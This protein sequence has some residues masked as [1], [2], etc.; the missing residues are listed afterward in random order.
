METNSGKD[1]SMS[2]LKA[3]KLASATAVRAALDPVQRAREKMIAALTEQKQMV[4]GHK[5][6]LAYLK[7]QNLGFEVPYL[8]GSMLRKILSR[9]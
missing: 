4:Q 9:L 1:H 6:V 2:H 7:N 5:H 8:S 3:L